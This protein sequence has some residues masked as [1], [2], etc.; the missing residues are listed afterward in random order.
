MLGICN[1][2]IFIHLKSFIFHS[3]NKHGR[4]FQRLIFQLFTHLS[5][6]MDSEIKEKYGFDPKL[7]SI[8]DNLQADVSAAY[9]V[10]IFMLD[11]KVTC[12]DCTFYPV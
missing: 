8:M 7:T 3:P 12:Q 4:F 5:A 9:L 1:F 6:V 11:Q 2:Y 10:L